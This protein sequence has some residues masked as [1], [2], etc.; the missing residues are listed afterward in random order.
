[1][2]VICI[3]ARVDWSHDASS[4]DDISLHITFGVM[5]QTWTELMVEAVTAACVSDPAFSRQP[6]RWFCQQS[7]F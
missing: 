2:L 7:R 3:I 5:A 6:A 1:M 4:T